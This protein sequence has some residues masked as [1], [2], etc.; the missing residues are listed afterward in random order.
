MK[1]NII[2]SYK[3]SELSENA[4]KVALEKHRYDFCDENLLDFCDEITDKI[5]LIFEDVKFHYTG[6]YSQGDGA[7]FTFKGLNFE[8]LF[9]EFEKQGNIFSAKA[10]EFLKENF[11]CEG[12]HHGRYYHEN[13]I[14]IE[15]NC[16]NENEKLNKEIQGFTDCLESLRYS[17]CKELYSQLKSLYEEFVSDEY[18]ADCLEMNEY[19]FLESGKDFAN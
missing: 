19:E 9:E 8:K 15:W 5:K 18:V 14:S 7:C 13:S 2:Y 3:F 11:T 12:V 10:K 4:K 16:E 1:E 6:F 17:L